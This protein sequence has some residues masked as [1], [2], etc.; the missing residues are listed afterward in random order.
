MEV[1]TLSSYTREE[2][3]QIA[4]KH[5]VPK[6]LKRHGLSGRTLRIADE[7][8]YALC[9]FYTR[10]AGVRTLERTIGAL[11]KRCKLVGAKAVALRPQLGDFGQKYKTDALRRPMKLALPAWLDSVGGESR[12]KLACCRAPARQLTGSLG[13][14]MKESAPAITYIRSIAER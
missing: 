7:A 14:V 6:Q 2:K 8:L 12:L 5:L 13:D 9:D 10:E 4:K 3:F 11:P 1:I